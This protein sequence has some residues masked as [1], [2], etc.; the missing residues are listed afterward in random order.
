M[1]ATL[2]KAKQWVWHGAGCSICLSLGKP[3]YYMFNIKG[4]NLWASRK[5][6]LRA[7]ESHK[8]ITGK[9]IAGAL[10]LIDAPISAWKDWDGCSLPGFIKPSDA[11]SH[12]AT[13]EELIQTDLAV[14]RVTWDVSEW[15]PTQCNNKPLSLIWQLLSIQ[16]NLALCETRDRSAFTVSG[17]STSHRATEYQW[18]MG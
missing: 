10:F 17:R 14:A 7:S 13:L 4:R 1:R 18:E 9:L 12:E 2:N 6:E 8:G 3:V 16:M 11:L 15:S 5:M